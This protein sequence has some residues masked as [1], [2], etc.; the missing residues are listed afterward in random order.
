LIEHK[1]VFDIADM[2]GVRSNAI[3]SAIIT[4]AHWRYTC[5]SSV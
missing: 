2:H 1:L 5:C 3:Q 4:A